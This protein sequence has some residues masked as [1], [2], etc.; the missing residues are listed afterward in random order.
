MTKTVIPG[1]QPTFLRNGNICKQPLLT[2]LKRNVPLPAPFFLLVQR[3]P[4][5]T[6][7]YSIN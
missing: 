5:T 7:N 4:I 2:L 6:K 3:F 1:F